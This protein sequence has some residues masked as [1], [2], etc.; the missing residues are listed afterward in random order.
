MK[1]N[2]FLNDENEKFFNLQKVE[3]FNW[4]NNILI[5]IKWINYIY[6]NILF[7]K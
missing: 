2:K 1:M 5:Y 4:N 3:K 6:Y 7:Y